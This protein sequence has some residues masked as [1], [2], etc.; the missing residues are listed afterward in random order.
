MKDVLEISVWFDLELGIEN[1]FFLVLW[2]GWLG[3][4]LLI[5]CCCLSFFLD[6][7]EMGVV[8]WVWLLVLWVFVMGNVVVM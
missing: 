3:V 6:I 4:G 1:I 2:Y 7:C 5:V 8:V